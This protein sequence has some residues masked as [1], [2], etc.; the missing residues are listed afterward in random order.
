M[1]CKIRE[2]DRILSIPKQNMP[3]ERPT[4][5]CF[6]MNGGLMPAQIAG[7]TFVGRFHGVFAFD[8]FAGHTSP[9]SSKCCNASTMRI[10]SS[11]L[12]PNGKSLIT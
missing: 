6:L 1:F 10:A 5:Y 8:Q 7:N 12:R 9:N 3:D 11:T 4:I 2:K